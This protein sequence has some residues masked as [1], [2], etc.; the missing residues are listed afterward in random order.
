MKSYYVQ[1]LRHLKELRSEIPQVCGVYKWW[2]KKVLLDKIISNLKLNPSCISDI[3]VVNKK[4]LR[5]C[6]ENEIIESTIDEELYCI[7]VGDTGNLKKRIL[8]Q[9]LGG[10]IKGSTLRM[11]IA[12]V[13]LGKV[14]EKVINDIEDEMII[15]VFYNDDFD[16]HYHIFQ[17]R[18]I[19]IYFRLLNN[20]DIDSNNM[21]YSNER[22]YEETT[23]G[24][25]RK[26]FMI[27]NLRRNLK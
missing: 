27:T 6:R 19:N 16:C 18:E 24:K 3:E 17:N 5:L 1:Q 21:L 22:H 20:D 23:N 13:L 12:A 25:F 4:V 9:H 2:C 15:D 11:T 26:S 7:Y 10:N 8:N 14:N